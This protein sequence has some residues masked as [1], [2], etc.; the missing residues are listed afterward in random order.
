M[1]DPQDIKSSV[2]TLLGICLKILK[3]HVCKDICTQ[4]SNAVLIHGGQDIERTK[5]S[6]DR[7]LD[8]DV[9]HI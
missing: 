2:T 4:M 8:K 5:A 1:E 9:V 7:W 6:F 3:N